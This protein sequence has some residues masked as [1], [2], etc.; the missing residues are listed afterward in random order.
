KCKDISNETE[1]KIMSISEA[2]RNEGFKSMKSVVH[3]VYE[4]VEERAG[5][6]STT[7][8]IPTGYRDLDFMTSGF[9][10]NDLIILAARPS[11]GKTAVAL[12]IA[13]H[14]GTSKDKY[15][16]AIFSLEMGADQIVTRMISSKGM[17]DATKLRQ[18][19]VEHQD[20]DNFPTALGQLADAHIFVDGSPG[21]RVRDIRSKCMRLVQ[22]PGLDRVIVVYLQLIQ[23]YGTRSSDSRQQ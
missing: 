10:R 13:G 11:M 23:G 7:T 8:G 5:Q 14:V 16:V 18:G 15:T 3:E 1:S 12:N 22:E 6:K 2:R 17:S 9:N 19:N 4:Q 21:I 20:W